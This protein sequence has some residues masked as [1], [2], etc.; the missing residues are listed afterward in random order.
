MC[1]R[2]YSRQ[3]AGAV[4]TWPWSEAFSRECSTTV[5]VDT[6][7]RSTS[8]HSRKSVPLFYTHAHTHARTHAHHIASVCLQ[9]LLPVFVVSY[10][11]KELSV[12]ETPANVSSNLVFD[13]I[14]VIPKWSNLIFELPNAN[15]F[16]NFLVCLFWTSRN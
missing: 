14:H 4:E 13:H 11:V 9:S 7:C 8:T 5:A 15:G 2:K 6:A 16:H 10:I 12:S 3:S 1:S